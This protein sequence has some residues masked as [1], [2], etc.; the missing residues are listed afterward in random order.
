MRFLIVKSIDLY[1]LSVSEASVFSVLF[2]RIYRINLTCFVI[3]EIKGKS[4]NGIIYV[5]EGYTYNVD[6]RQR[7]HTYRCSSRRITGCRGLAKVTEDGK[8]IVNPFHNHAP[9]NARI[10]KYTLKQEML[11]L[12]RETLQTPKN[13]FDDISRR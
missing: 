10:Q 2:I 1:C 8:I 7:I 6:K 12:S 13:I 5:Y 11:R 9:D 4:K 3:E